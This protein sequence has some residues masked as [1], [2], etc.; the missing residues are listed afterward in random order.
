MATAGAKVSFMM[1][2]VWKRWGHVFV[3]ALLLPL[4]LSSA[5]PMFARVLG[6][7]AVHVCKCEIRGGHSTCGCPIC[8]PDR[9]D[10]RLSESSIRGKCGDDDLTFGAALGS[11]VAPPAGVTVLPPDVT[12]VLR[13]VLPPRLAAVFLTPPTP[14]P[15]AALCA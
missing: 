12:G 8:N 6:G 1:R 14:P 9:D 10:L 7:P 5:L 11:A 13:P 15:R 4:A 3:L 2:G